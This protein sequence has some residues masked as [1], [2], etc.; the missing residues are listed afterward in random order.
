MTMLS[1]FL[2]AGQTTGDPFA[3]GA[4]PGGL[5]APGVYY[6]A[7]APTRRLVAEPM[8]VAA[9]VGVAPRGPAW[10]RIEDPLQVDGAAEGA[11]ARSVAVPVDSWDDYVERFGAFDAPGLLPHAVATFFAQGGRRAWVV[12]I[13]HDEHGRD[14][15]A[16]VPL[17]CAHHDLAD[18]ARGRF[19]QPVVNTTDG[20][21]VRLRAA[22]EGT[23]GQRLIATLSFTPRPIAVLPGADPAELVLDA[24]TRLVAGDL[25]RLRSD[26]GQVMLRTVQRVFTRGRVAAPLADRVAALDQPVFFAA[27][28]IEHV[29]AELEI[30]DLDPSRRRHE[31]FT[32]L[33]L[34]PAHPRYLADVLVAESRLVEMAGTPGAIEVRDPGLPP[35]S[36]VPVTDTGLAGEDRWH[37]ITPADV[38]GR[39]AVGD[40]S[41][42]EGLDALLH[43]PEVATVVVPDLYSPAELPTT[44]PVDLEGVFAGPTFEPCLV[45][46]PERFPAPPA[47]PLTGLHLDPTDPAQ[48]ET[49]IAR[50][51]DLVAVAERLR[52][53]ALLD[54]PPRLPA[55]AVDRWRARFDSSCAAA[56]F[57]W[58]RAPAVDVAA[59]GRSPSGTA[60][61][62]EVPPSAVAAGLIARCE[63][64][65]GVPR[66]PANEPAAGVVDVADVVDDARHGDLHRQGIDVFHR[67]PD[68]VWLSGTRTLSLDRQWRQLTVRRLVHLVERS[69][70]HQLQWT[71]FEPNDAMLRA[72]L[73]RSLDGLLGDLFAIGAFAGTT[74]AQSW[75]VRV[76]DPATSTREPDRGQ[77][78]VEVGV[79]PA[80]PIEFIVVRV[81]LDAEGA[82]EPRLLGAATAMT[83]VPGG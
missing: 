32:G 51:Q 49:I 20:L 37:L 33:G 57:P 50:Q 15:S 22:N 40:E 42:L 47:L 36:S 72:G 82:I 6:A 78:V 60:P 11:R 23:W 64:R 52:A 59:G 5:G 9:F 30:V 17:G 77:V 34:Q 67:Q 76:A 31:R 25:V 10:V 18:P 79:A 69:V 55:R 46:P 71:V 2:S 53:V 63:L 39:L 44:E 7:A 80:E 3:G 56:Y 38:F 48:L 83:G 35:V 65:S 14:G 4:H 26:T 19:D 29:E 16:V 43:A 45:R 21:A 61:L 12:R 24:G 41:G 81:A 54:V 27:V 1:P 13:V 70:L 8:N 68:G 73:R 75:F 62:V 58:L 74:P 28:T 66:G